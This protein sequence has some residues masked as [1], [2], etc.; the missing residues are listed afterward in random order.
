M[1]KPEKKTADEIIQ[2]IAETLAETD[3]IFIH[4]IANLV[5]GKYVKYEAGDFIVYPN[6]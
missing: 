6:K 4:K 3:D 2:M 5:L 1:D